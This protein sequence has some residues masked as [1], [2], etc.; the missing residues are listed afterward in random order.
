M[1]AAVYAKSARH[2]IAVV[3]TAT[4]PPLPKHGEVL[5]RVRAAA[6]NP[7][8]LKL[9]RIPIVGWF[10]TGNVVGFDW[11]GVVEAVPQDS[12][13]KVGDAV[14]GASKGGMADY[15]LAPAFKVAL[16]PKTMTFAE[17]ASLPVAAMTALQG[18][19][20]NGLT[21]G[22]RLLV[23]GASG[24]VGSAAVQIGKAMGAHVTGLCSGASAPLVH[25]LGADEVVDY[26]DASAMAAIGATEAGRFHLIFDTV[27]SPDA[28]DPDYEARLRKAGALAA[29]GRYAACTSASALDLVRGLI[30]AVTGWRVQRRGYDCV[31]CE[32]KGE[33]LAQLGAWADGGKLRAVLQGGAPVP[34]TQ[35]AIDAA[36]DALHSRRVRGKL[37]VDVCD[38]GA[39]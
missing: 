11:A 36:Y 4:K 22:E 20:R 23:V 3:S 35:E 24:G 21:A 19:H 28:C 9:P 8:D 2:G 38:A 25:S 29:G 1:K 6:Q 26:T 17:A 15:V 10:T 34:F 16:K 12:P 32:H 39:K 14:Y 7:A 27:S 18:L 30:Q 33:D 13:F 5:V 37:V 31:F